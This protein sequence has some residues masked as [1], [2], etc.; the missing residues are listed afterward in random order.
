VYKDTGTLRLIVDYNKLA[1]KYSVQLTDFFPVYL[2][3]LGRDANILYI[4]HSAFKIINDS[5]VYLKEVRS[6]LINHPNAYRIDKDLE[7]HYAKSTTLQNF[8]TLSTIK[9][10]Y[11]FFNTS[12]GAWLI[13]TDGNV[14][15]R[16]FLKGKKPVAL[17]ATQKV[18]SGSLPL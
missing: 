12:D 13:D 3:H 17:S 18:I 6:D 10:T 2:P 1:A 16:P 14:A 5:L 4:G 15:A 11:A 9:N 7:A 8:N